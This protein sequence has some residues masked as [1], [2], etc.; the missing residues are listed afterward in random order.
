[1]FVVLTLAPVRGHAACIYWHKAAWIYQQM[2]PFACGECEVVVAERAD[3]A[4]PFMVTMVEQRA[5]GRAFD[6]RYVGRRREEFFGEENSC[7]LFPE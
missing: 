6:N 4:I 1:M 5:A 2:H 3:F 7:C